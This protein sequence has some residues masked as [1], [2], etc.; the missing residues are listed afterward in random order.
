[1]GWERRGNKKYFYRKR[2]EGDRVVSKYLTADEAQAYLA[3]RAEAKAREEEAKEAIQATEALLQP[4]AE[5]DA[6]A[7]SLC[8]ATLLAE[9][10]H[11]PDRWRWR[12]RTK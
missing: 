6:L 9:G 7:D 1:M 12:K 5:F 11:R 2:R 10:Y 8:S 3:E 4:L